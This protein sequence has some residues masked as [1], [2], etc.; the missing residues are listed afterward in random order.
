M[1]TVSLKVLGCR[2]DHKFLTEYIRSIFDYQNTNVF[3]I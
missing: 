2:Q 1:K 3:T